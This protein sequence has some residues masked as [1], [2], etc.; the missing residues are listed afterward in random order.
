MFIDQ[1]HVNALVLKKT[2]Y[3][4]YWQELG[5]LKNFTHFVAADFLIRSDIIQIPSHRP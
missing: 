3:Q 1:A 2:G 5:R 4:L